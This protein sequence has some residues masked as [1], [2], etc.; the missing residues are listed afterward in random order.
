MARIACRIDDPRWRPLGDV[1]T[2]VRAAVRAALKASAR[3][4]PAVAEVAVVLADDAA[5]RVLNARW[6]KKDKA[7]NVLSFPAGGAARDS[8]GDVVVAF[9]TMRDEAA[10][11]GKT[12]SDHLSHLVVHGVL[13]LLG[14][15]HLSARAAADME[16]REVAALARLGIADPYAG[17]GSGEHR[18][19][20]EGRVPLAHCETLRHGNFASETR[21]SGSS[22][23]LS[24]RSSF[25]N[26][27]GQGDKAVAA[28]AGNRDAVA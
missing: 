20:L 8:L 13:H 18:N 21:H 24:P 19:V 25:R 17:T 1:R 22:R 11:D 28:T 14:Y 15:D 12:L 23:R 26:K 27:R 3:K 2:V 7:T 6:R 4:A 16:A 9:E 10:V 5:V